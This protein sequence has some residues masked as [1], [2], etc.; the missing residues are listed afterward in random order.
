M[1]TETMPLSNPRFRAEAL[2]NPTFTTRTVQTPPRSI[3]RISS[4]IILAIWLAF[5][6]SCALRP[7]T[8]EQRNPD[9]D[10]AFWQSVESADVIYVG[11]THN[12][13]AHHEYEKHLV[14]GLLARKARFAIGWEMFEQRQQTILNQWTA[15]KL[16]TDELFEQ[17]E[18]QQRWAVYS[19]VYRE[20]L[21]IARKSRIANIAL[22]ASSE[23]VHKVA[24]G[25]SLNPAEQMTIPTGFESNE[26]GFRNFTAMMGGH[27]G[28]QE[29]DL[30]RFFAAQNLWDETM[31]TSVLDFKRRN[32]KT[33][34]IAFVGRGH[35][36]ARFGIPFYV[37][38]KSSINQLTLFP[39]G[40]LD[41]AAGRKNL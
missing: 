26:A 33:K 10:F 40:Q 39:R 31:A 1:L 29:T 36:M 5:L 19:P 23:T 27:P 35:V 6:T 11:E 28:V 3:D 22:N 17:T 12:D 13:S 34:L 18:F 38:Q 20:L 4:K 24:R 30:R 32:P 9:P 16:S 41:L 37:K 8:A 7:G 2:L 25:E 14:L 21:E 15:K